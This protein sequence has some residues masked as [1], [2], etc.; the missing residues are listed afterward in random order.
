MNTGTSNT[1][2]GYYSGIGNLTGSYNVLLGT[3]AGENNG[4]GNNNVYIGYHVANQND[5]SGNIFIGYN[6][7]ATVS[8]TSNKLII[9]NNSSN[10]LIEGDFSEK[11]VTINDVL[12]LTPR[13][14]APIN[15]VEGQIYVNST[16]HHIYCYL[17]GTWKPLD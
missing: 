9:A 2:M 13:T 14:T 16:D 12:T 8:S 5:G 4:D 11:K 15:P 1:F 3:S 17:N 6:A 7:G 10:N